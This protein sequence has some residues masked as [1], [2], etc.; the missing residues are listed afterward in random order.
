MFNAHLYMI[1]L[2]IFLQLTKRIN[3]N[4]DSSKDAGTQVENRDVIIPPL[5]FDL[6]A[7]ERLIQE[8]S[9]KAMA[10]KWVV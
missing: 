1:H 10:S 7:V 9:A 8:T 6:E 5:P 4:S 3:E 2:L